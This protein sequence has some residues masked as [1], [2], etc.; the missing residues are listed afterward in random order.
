MKDLLQKVSFSSSFCCCYGQINGVDVDLGDFGEKYDR[1]PDE[2]EEFGCGDMQFTRKKSSPDIL[3]KYGIT[4][5]GYD[6]ICTML[7]EKLSFGCCGW[8]V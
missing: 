3:D 8:C 1:E 5:A 7:E 6:Y 2:K 4:D